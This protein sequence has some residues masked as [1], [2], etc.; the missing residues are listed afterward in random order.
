[1]SRSSAQLARL[2][3]RVTSD[4]KARYQYTAA[5]TG[6]SLHEFMVS[7]LEA[8]ARQI[9]DGTP[10]IKLS[11]RDSVVFVEALLNPPTPGVTLRAPC[12]DYRANIGEQHNSPTSDATN[13]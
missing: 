8:A 10:I 3:L 11:A 6:R 2:Y 5:A 4:Q 12:A 7:S 13:G 1:M 9:V